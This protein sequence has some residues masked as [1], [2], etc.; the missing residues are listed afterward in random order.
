MEETMLIDAFLNNE[1]SFRPKTAEEFERF[2]VLI[3]VLNLSM[4]PSFNEYLD[5]YYDPKREKGIVGNGLPRLRQFS[6][7]EFENEIEDLRKRWEPIQHGFLTGQRYIS[8]LSDKQRVEACEFFDKKGY[9]TLSG[10]PSLE[11]WGDR[12]GLCNWTLGVMRDGAIAVVN[13]GEKGGSINNRYSVTFFKEAFS[14]NFEPLKQPGMG[15]KISGNKYLLKA[16][17]EFLKSKGFNNLNNQFDE[18]SLT[19][20]SS[21]IQYSERSHFIILNQTNYEAV[22]KSYDLP[23]DWD[24]FVKDTTVRTIKTVQRSITVNGMTI[25]NSKLE[26][27]ENAVFRIADRDRVVTQQEW[28]AIK[29]VFNHNSPNFLIWELKVDSISIGC[30]SGFTRDDF[31]QIENLIEATKKDNQ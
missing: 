24:A 13:Q 22:N 16:A 26:T 12:N 18:N 1:A 3:Q 9:K 10:K 28:D 20:N 4:S 11:I 5:L 21:I 6:L 27:K 17:V 19:D 23:R 29:N 15:H 31:N 7:Q 30:T 25:D 8:P 2:K 14:Y